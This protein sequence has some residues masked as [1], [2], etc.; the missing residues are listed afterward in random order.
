MMMIII[1]TTATPKKQRMKNLRERK[2]RA[3]VTAHIQKKTH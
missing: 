3:V 2:S 1:I